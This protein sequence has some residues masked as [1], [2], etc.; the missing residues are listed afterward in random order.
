MTHV[1]W[2]GTYRGRYITRRAVVRYLR[3]ESCEQSST[4]SHDDSNGNAKG[5]GGGL[6]CLEGWGS[7]SL[8]WP[9]LAES[10]PPAEAGA[11]AQVAGGY[12]PSWGTT[13]AG[14]NRHHTHQK[15]EKPGRDFKHSACKSW[16]ES[17]P[18]DLVVVFTVWFLISNCFSRKV[19]TGPNI[20]PTL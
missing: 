10:D 5:R 12:G 9:Q 18:R 1:S 2:R 14:G 19:E 13:P 3:V 15:M 20:F 11:A 8:G 4:K 17:S 7:Q 16:T 6:C